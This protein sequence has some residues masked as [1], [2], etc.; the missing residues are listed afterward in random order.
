MCLNQYKC[1][2]LTCSGDSIEK[3]QVN[4]IEKIRQIHRIDFILI[5]R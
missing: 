2:K 5:M 4:S 3:I 1:R